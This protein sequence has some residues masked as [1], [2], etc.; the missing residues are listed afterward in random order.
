MLIP[1]HRFVADRSKRFWRNL[2]ETELDI[3]VTV[4]D[5]DNG[6]LTTDDATL[7]APVSNFVDQMFSR[8]V[9]QFNGEWMILLTNNCV[10]KFVRL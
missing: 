3:T 6:L 8:C 4:V 1:S 7:V 10:N 2:A 5:Q 9:V